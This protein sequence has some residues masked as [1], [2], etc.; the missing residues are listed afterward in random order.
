M[1][2]WEIIVDI[3]MITQQ[4]KMNIKKITI[5]IEEIKFAKNEKIK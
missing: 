4:R 1:T 5:L 3:N 2:V